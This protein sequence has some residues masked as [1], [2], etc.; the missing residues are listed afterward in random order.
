MRIEAVI[1]EAW[2]I[3]EVLN[4]RGDRALDDL[5]EA[6]MDRCM[7][8][9]EHAA[10]HGP[11]AFAE[12]RTHNVC[13]DPKIWQFD[14]TGTLRLLYFYEDG[15]MIV[16]TKMFYKAGGKSGKTPPALIKAAKLIYGD[17]QNAKLH[18]TLELIEIDGEDYED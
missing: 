18:G 7:A 8:F 15:K 14:V 17:Y 9:L 3:Y 16:L 4:A 10:T 5:H 11:E 13:N 1:K 6:D 2:S 12:N